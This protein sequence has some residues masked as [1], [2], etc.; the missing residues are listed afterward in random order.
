MSLPGNAQNT[1]VYVDNISVTTVNYGVAN[2][3]NSGTY[4][5]AQEFD[6][7]STTDFFDGQ[8]DELALYNKVLL[9]TINFK[10]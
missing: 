10:F 4:S 9:F 3:N 2:W 8:L 1:K 5:I 6:T 7:N